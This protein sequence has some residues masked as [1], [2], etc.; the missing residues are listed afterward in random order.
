[1]RLTI[2]FYCGAWGI[3]GSCWTT[4]SLQKSSKSFGTYS[5]SLSGHKRFTVWLSKLNRF[6]F[7]Q[8]SSVFY[9]VNKFSKPSKQLRLL[10]DRVDGSVSQEIVYNSYKVF[11]TSHWR[12]IHW[13]TNVV[14]YQFKQSCC[15]TFCFLRERLTV[16]LVHSTSFKVSIHSLHGIKIQPSHYIYIVQ[17]FK[18]IVPQMAV[19]LVQQFEW[20]LIVCFSYTASLVKNGCVQFVKLAVLMVDGVLL[21]I[22]VNSTCFTFEFDSNSFFCKWREKRAF[23]FFEV[24]GRKAHNLRQFLSLPFNSVKCKSHLPYA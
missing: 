20:F 8:S 13:S 23:F 14:M 4:R 18:V 3:V 22:I 19:L 11:G 7:N 17:E 16:L 6:T 10:L 1:M 21:P 9:E 24:L 5:P 12:Y 2:S 15:D